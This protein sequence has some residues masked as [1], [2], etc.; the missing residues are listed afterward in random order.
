LLGAV[1]I[2]KRPSETLTP[3]EDKLLTDL[4]GQAGLVLRNV[5]L[6]AEL[7]A[8]LTE[9]SRQAGALRASRQR[10]VATQDAE[11]RRLER[12]IHDG[13]QQNLVAL[14]VKLRLAASLA[15]RDPQRARAAVKALEDESDQALRTLTALA[16][17]IYPPL[18]RDQGLVTALRAEADR[19]PLPATV[20]ADGANRLPPEVEAAVY[21]VC[22][23]AMQNVTKHARASR[24]EIN[25]RAVADELS[26][27]ITDDGAGFDVAKDAHG[28]GLRN[29]IDRIE[30]IGGRLEIRSAA[31]QGTTVTGTVPVGA[32]EAVS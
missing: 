29:M 1:S 3:V 11:R 17:G 8:R 10:I 7:Q 19:M 15:K 5:R 25:I 2:N 31:R 6:T 22:L 13:A 18:L 9:I 24:V 12:N 32:L 14:T 4:A 30:G 26:F 16:R 23:E 27:E 20:R 28:S 21:F